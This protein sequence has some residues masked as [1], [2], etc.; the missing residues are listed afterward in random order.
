MKLARLLAPV[1]GTAVLAASG[2]IAMAQPDGPQR[3]RGMEGRSFAVEVT[4]LAPTPIQNCYT[5]EEDGVW[6]DDA[7]R[8]P[9]TDIRIP[10]SWSQNGVGATTS[11]SAVLLDGAIS[12]H[13]TV[14]PAKGSG[15]LQL[16]ATTNIAAGVL[17]PNAPALTVHSVGSE[18]E[19]CPS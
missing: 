13:G 3:L 2:G 11:Y 9:G 12:Q 15:V 17:G 16:S 18:V 6:I 14:T 8:V 10:G 1:L 4:G 7:V 19:A 5:F